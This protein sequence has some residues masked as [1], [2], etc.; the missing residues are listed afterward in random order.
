MQQH[1][2]Q[3]FHFQDYSFKNSNSEKTSICLTQS[4]YYEKLSNYKFRKKNRI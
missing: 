3:S 1:A 4:I 2:P